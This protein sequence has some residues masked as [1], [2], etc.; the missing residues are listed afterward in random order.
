MFYVVKV[1]D[2]NIFKSDITV[3]ETTDSLEK[4]Q[5]LRDALCAIHPDT[6]YEVM[7]VA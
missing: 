5:A 1:R 3:I 6:R 7:V 4:A 2:Y